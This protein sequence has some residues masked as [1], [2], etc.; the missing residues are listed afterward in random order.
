MGKVTQGAPLKI[1]AKDWNSFIDAAAYVADRQRQEQGG[2]LKEGLSNGVIRVMNATEDTLPIYTAVALRGR[3]KEVP[4]YDVEGTEVPTDV[5]FNA[6]LEIT[7]TRPYAVLQEPLEPGA[8]GKARVMGVT[9]VRFTG[10]AET[11]FAAP[12]AKG[13]MVASESGSARILCAPAEA[14]G[15]GIVMLGGGGGGG[16]TVTG[17]DVRLCEITDNADAQGSSGNYAV[18]IFSLDDEGNAIGSGTL[19]IAE[20]ALGSKLPVGTRLL[21]HLVTLRTT[22]GN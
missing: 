15:W 21:G 9:P 8:I 1:P 2:P 3:N 13:R 12:N 17:S 10:E 22:G 16:T 7:E 14:D 5:Y 20:I 19:F 11:A 6:S 18:D 4:D